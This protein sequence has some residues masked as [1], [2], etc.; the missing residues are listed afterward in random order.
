MFLAIEEMI[1]ST[2]NFVLGC[3]LGL[4]IFI[5]IAALAIVALTSSYDDV[6]RDQAK[7]VE[8]MQKKIDGIANRLEALSKK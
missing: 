3:E 5:A 6:L 4:I 7:K 2:D 8:E 1:P